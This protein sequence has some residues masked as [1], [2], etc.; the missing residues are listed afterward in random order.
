MCHPLW[1]LAAHSGSLE[2][3]S[4][5]FSHLGWKMRQRNSL[6]LLFALSLSKH[7]AK[8][9]SDFQFC[10]RLSIVQ[11]KISHLIYIETYLRFNY[12]RVRDQY[13]DNQ[14]MKIDSNFKVV[15]LQLS[16]KMKSSFRTSLIFVLTCRNKVS[17]FHLN[18]ENNKVF[19]YNL[20][21]LFINL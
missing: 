3:S 10:I 4:C 15:Y 11:G 20:M 21:L 18:F 2:T 6:Y 1:L 19:L 12:F 16:W 9:S 8:T 7:W 13:L 5:F 17:Y 14:N